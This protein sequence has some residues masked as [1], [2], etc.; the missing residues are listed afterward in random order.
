MIEVLVVE[1][2]GTINKGIHK[3]EEH[4]KQE[5][6]ESANG[7]PL[8]VLIIQ[9]DQEHERL[10]LMK[11][12]IEFQQEHLRDFHM[13]LTNIIEKN[14]DVEKTEK[15]APPK[16]SE[17]PDEPKTQENNPESVTQPLS[18]TENPRL[19][20]LEQGLCNAISVLSGTKMA[21]YFKEIKQLLADLTVLAGATEMPEAERVTDLEAGLQNAVEVLGGAYCAVRSKV[22]QELRSDLIEL[23]S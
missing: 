18:K 11:A 21:S 17:A 14:N 2:L 10:D 22:T 13:F 19:K 20:N 4:R 6:Q 1:M 9:L 3:A 7:H 12:K 5:R 15:P 8:D 23:L 16:A